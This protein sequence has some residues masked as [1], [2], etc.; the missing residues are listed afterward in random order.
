[1]ATTGV[2]HAAIAAAAQHQE[3]LKNQEKLQQHAAAIEQSHNNNQEQQRAQQAQQ[4]PDTDDHRPA[5]R[6][7]SNRTTTTT[8]N[9]QQQK[10]IAV[11]PTAVSDTASGSA[12]SDDS[13]TMTDDDDDEDDDDDDDDNDDSDQSGEYMD[14]DPALRHAPLSKPSQ[15]PATAKRRHGK[16]PQR[17]TSA[18]L[19]ARSPPSAT[20]A[21]NTGAFLP[22]VTDD[23]LIAIAGASSSRSP[24]GS[25]IP[26]HQHP[27]GP[28]DYTHITQALAQQPL[29][30]NSSQQTISIVQKL[31]S[32]GEQGASIEARFK[33]FMRELQSQMYTMS[34][35]VDVV[36]TARFSTTASISNLQASLHNLQA[37]IS[38][39]D[40]HHHHSSVS[41][42]ASPIPSTSAAGM[43]VPASA[44]L[45]VANP[46]SE[47]ANLQSA[48]EMGA[49]LQRQLSEIAKQ[50]GVEGV[51]SLGADFFNSLNA[52]YSLDDPLTS[53]LLADPS[54]V[55]PPPLPSPSN[56]NGIGGPS[57]TKRK[58]TRK[59]SAGGGA[60]KARDG[61]GSVSPG[62]DVKQP[63]K[64]KPGLSRAVRSSMF[65]LLGIQLASSSTKFHGY[66]TSPDLPDFTDS[67]TFDSISGVRVFRWEWDKTIRQSSFNSA[68]AQ[69]IQNQVLQDRQLGLLNDIPDE[70]WA[71][72]E[73]A[74][75]SAYTN[76]R[77][78]REAQVNPAKKM[79]KE[80][81]RK[82]G[83]KRGLKEEKR[84]RRTT[85]FNDSM[86]SGGGGLSS[87]Q[88]WQNLLSTFTSEGEDLQEALD[89]KYMSS[90]DEVDTNDPEILAGPVRDVDVLGSTSLVAGEKAFWVHR[91]V[92]RSDRL[93]QAFRELDALK[94][95][96]KAYRRI[97]GET[98]A[99]YPPEGTPAW[100]ISETW[101]EELLS[102][103]GVMRYQSG[104]TKGKGKGKLSD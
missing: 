12:H 1:M 61:D 3:S 69:A 42:S 26:N 56:G 66:T 72:L 4:Q 8:S 59:S 89:I 77:R 103:G 81:H 99:E 16:Q 86:A 30:T 67:P 97:L 2:I 15:S 10:D 36:E 57:T 40:A 76:L 38:H 33:S 29:A 71:G 83:K 98:R 58:Y 79:K 73:D 20:F 100:M 52:Q 95:A 31:S 34:Q 70:D 7:R 51:S 62:P 46:I 53:S 35:R 24:S 60:K 54:G 22:L 47:A 44:A 11:I 104:K 84:N 27:S 78:E 55:P 23:P 19:P 88:T 18:R 21:H 91:P 90:E 49:Q 43:L 82:R 48:E 101:K 92:W 75:D 9:Q 17:S 45:N 80:A 32:A 74:I 63:R 37:A 6:R 13:D 14:V 28:I 65:K 93:S 39:T 50:H 5:K 102:R 64:R 41:P 87:N 68:F 96:E 94:P 85:A 25:S